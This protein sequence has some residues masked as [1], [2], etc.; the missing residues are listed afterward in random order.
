MEEEQDGQQIPK[1]QI[2]VH[3]ALGPYFMDKDKWP[4]L[5]LPGDIA[6]RDIDLSMEDESEGVCTQ[7]MSMI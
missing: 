2:M 3:G 7:E 6:E 4:E 5:H 1:G